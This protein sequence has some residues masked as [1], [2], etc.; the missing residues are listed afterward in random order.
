V[1]FGAPGDL[2]SFALADLAVCI[3]ADLPWLP[4]AEFQPGACPIPTRQAPVVWIDYDNGRRRTDD[5]FAALGRA[6]NLPESIPLFYYTMPTPPLN[7][8]DD[9]SIAQLTQRVINHGAGVVIIDNLRTVSGGADENSAD[10]GD[11][12]YRLRRL[13]E[14]S[15]AA[16][17]V[18]HHQR[19]GNGIT[20]VRSGDTLRGH[21]SIEAS[22]DLAL[23]VEREPYSESITFRATKSRGGT[24][25]P[26]GATFTYD[27]DDNGELHSALFYGRVVEDTNSNTAIENA[28]RMSLVNTSLNQSALVKAVKEIVQDPGK[29][30]VLDTI[31]RMERGGILVARKGERGA[32]VYALS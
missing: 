17:V 22:L 18:I 28:I 5:R 14:D 8:S 31:K 19:K 12:M 9:V 4:E 6:R 32:L 13:A 27:T 11:V 20:G 7:A 25:Y 16:V 1:V 26:F 10:M 3:A 24:V 2:K 21:S 29:N 30:R 15:G 23:C